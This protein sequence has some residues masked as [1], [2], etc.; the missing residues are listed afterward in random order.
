MKITI[1]Y[2]NRVWIKQYRRKDGTLLHGHFRRKPNGSF[3]AI[4]IIINN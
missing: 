4:N 2:E 1:Q 3:N